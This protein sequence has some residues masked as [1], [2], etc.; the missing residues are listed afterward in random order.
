MGASI[1]SYAELEKVGLPYI[2]TAVKKKIRSSTLESCSAWMTNKTDLVRVVGSDLSLRSVME[3]VL[4][5]PDKWRVFVSFCESVMSEKEQ[6]ERE[7]VPASFSV[8]PMQS[9]L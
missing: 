8:T 1:V 3:I 4:S 9:D 7:V 2:L 5:D 6:A